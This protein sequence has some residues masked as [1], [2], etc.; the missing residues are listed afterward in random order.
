M[1]KR[2]IIAAGRPGS[3][4]SDERLFAEAAGCLGSGDWARAE[5]LCQKL[6]KRR[7]KDPALDEMLGLVSMQ[8]NRP[9]AAVQRFRRAIDGGLRTAGVYSNLALAL[10]SLGDLPGAVEAARTAARLGPDQAKLQVNLGNRLRAAG[11][12]EEAVA[13]YRA[14]IKLSPG[15]VAA[16]VGLGNAHTAL[17]ASGEAMAQYRRAL[18]LRPDHAKAFYH[19]TLITKAGTGALD[20]GLADSFRGRIEQDAFGP[21][22]AALVHNALGLIADR[23]GDC[24]RAFAHFRTFNELIAAER[25]AG[26]QPYD[27]T[28]HRRWVGRII[29]AFPADSFAAE[30]KR[31]G[32]SGRPLFIVGMPRSGTTLVE[33]ILASH[34]AVA[35]GGELLLVQDL[36]GRVPDYPGGIARL[37]RDKLDAL[38]ERYLEALSTIDPDTERVTDKLPQNFLHLG[39]IARLLPRAR[40]VHCLRDPV[41]TCLSC[42]FQNFPHG[43][44]YANDLADLGAFYRDYARVMDHWNRV[45]PSRPIEVGYEALVNDPQGT[46][47]QLLDMLALPWDPACL[48]F[49]ESRRPVLTASQW[50][51]RQAITAKAVGRSRPYRPHLG[52]LLDA[53]GDL[54]V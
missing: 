4:G 15:L 34:P 26:G 44:A 29:D 1:P 33:Q 8:K 14:A 2:P 32:A 20:R 31:E 35:A 38:A 50:Q 27:R 39:F 18:E 13:A 3:R 17:G 24:D 49:R 10:S 46:V 51:V 42:Y 22:D 11:Q 12:V 41:D 5:A 37:S 47:R 23:E 36:A 16:H 6:A 40:V 45:L 28:A 53:L 30:T 19:L 43:H 52:P 48:E 9:R 21:G 54:A 7:G 25:P